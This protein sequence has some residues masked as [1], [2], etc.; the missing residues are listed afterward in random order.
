MS[1][2][3]KTAIIS[4]A[5]SGIGLLCAQELAE[6]GAHV[7]LTDINLDAVTKAAD[8]ISG[9]GGSA[10]PAKVDVTDYSQIEQAV[11]LGIETFGK[12]DIL[13]NCAGGA[14]T[15]IL[16]RPEPFEERSIEVIDWGID[17]NL[18]GA[19]YFCRAVVPNM[20]DNKSGVM[21]NLGSIEGETGSPAVEY[22]TAKSAMVGMTKSLA[23]V[24]AP[25]GVRACCVSPGPVLTRPEMSK[26]WTLLG[27]AAE[28]KEV[29]D[30][31]LYLCSDKAAFIT[32]SHHLI[33]G[34][35]NCGAG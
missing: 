4:G 22:A 27:R 34:G 31:I 8:D 24:G 28:T 20:I 35:R 3:D 14:P 32:G 5:A 29:V 17:V 7:V 26:M 9:K 23:L 2:K 13:I 15:R 11:N 30:F 1:F 18:K 33:D 25:H 19:L 6:D 10:V 16:K 21:I 12:I